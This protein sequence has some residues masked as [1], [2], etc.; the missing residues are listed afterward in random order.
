M[1]A[2]KLNGKLKLTF[3]TGFPQPAKIEDS[4]SAQGPGGH[5][6]VLLLIDTA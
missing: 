1:L 4:V 6:E 3:V 5:F 2:A